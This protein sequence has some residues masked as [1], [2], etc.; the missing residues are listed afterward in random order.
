MKRAVAVMAAVALVA[1]QASPAFAYLKF[2]V[3]AGNRTIAL[4]WARTPVRYF[5]TDRTDI[6]ISPNDFQSAL[7]RAFATWQAV[8][9]SSMAY[10]F[11]GFTSAPPFQEDGQST[12]GFASRPELNRVLASTNILVD[13][14]TGEI[15]EADIFFNTASQW[16]VAP[17][18]E[19]DKYDLES[20]ALHEIGHLS[21]LAHSALGET[22]IKP[23]GG[24]RVLAAEAVMFPIAYPAGNILGR[25]L[26]SDDIAGISELYP[27]GGFA[28]TTGSVSG[29]V[30]RDGRG[31]FGAHIIA[32]NPSTGTL[33]GGFTLDDQGHF[34]ILG[35]SPGP[36]LIRV[37]PIDDA[38]VESFFAS[39]AAVAVDF[40][41]TFFDRLAI[42]PRG[43]DTGA[44]EVRVSSK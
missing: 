31:V 36:H 18:G 34:A 3:T 33:T 22:E 11:V 35:L 12:L 27:D 2:G 43:G 30:T 40:R 10:Q 41:V 32:F 42:V 13:D 25:S 37:E 24:R 20:V 14:T 8:P 39:T 19:A 23:D 26:R 29:R 28:A 16:S 6:N 21:G 44:L 7:G 9:T 17:G 4:K 15:V 5:V 1:G 38:D